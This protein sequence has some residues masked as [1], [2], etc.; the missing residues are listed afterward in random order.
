MKR[1]DFVN[2]RMSWNETR[3]NINHVDESILEY[4]RVFAKRIKPLPSEP[5]L[6]DFY[7]P[8]DQKDKNGELLFVP[9][10]TAQATYALYNYHK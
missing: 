7:F 10:G 5:Q 2:K 1:F 6:S 4:Y 3:A 9:V 8:P